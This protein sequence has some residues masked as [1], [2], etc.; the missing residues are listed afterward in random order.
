MSIFFPIMVVK[1]DLGSSEINMIFLIL[2]IF[3]QIWLVDILDNF[4]FF[5]FTLLK[6]LL[7]KFDFI[8]M[9]NLSMELNFPFFLV[10]LCSSGASSTK[11]NPETLVVEKV[12]VSRYRYGIG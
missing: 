6:D 5:K 7:A 4:C 9:L 2:S 11:I 8:L 1:L 12:E 10:R 3:L